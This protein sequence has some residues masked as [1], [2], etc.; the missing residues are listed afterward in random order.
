MALKITPLSAAL[1]AEATGVDLREP[2]DAATLRRL[3]EAILEHIVLVIRDQRFTPA[4]Y[5][6]AARLF[7]EP[8]RQHYSQYQMDGFPDINLLSSRDVERRPDGRP[9]L[10]GTECWHTD[11][12]NRAE[13]PKLTV[14]FA[15]R[16]PSKGGD[17][18][19]ANMRL[20]YKALPDDD[21]KAYAGLRTVNALEVFVGRSDAPTLEIDKARYAERAV[22]PLVRTHPENHT[23]ALYFHPTKTE[24]VTGMSREQSHAFIDEL[25]ERVIRPQIVYRH[26][27]RVGDMLLC[28]NRSALHRAH[29]DYDPEEGRLLHRI[30]LKGDR[31]F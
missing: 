2:Q 10:Q 4:E 22:H 27:W 1:G 3:E 30:I 15:L 31:P 18:S 13:P 5:L 11:H 19:F 7:G 24:C 26:K 25:L 16:L 23:K 12:T 28:D 14:L 20:A 21:K 6:A 17:T 29:A 9:H 8:M